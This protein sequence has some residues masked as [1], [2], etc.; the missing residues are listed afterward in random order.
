MINRAVKFANS[1]RVDECGV[2]T[3]FHIRVL[4]KFFLRVNS[5]VVMLYYTVVS[6]FFF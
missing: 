2:G 5:V 6:H 3:L 1:N 4:M